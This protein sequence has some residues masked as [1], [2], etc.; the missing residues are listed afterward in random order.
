MT[1]RA[2]WYVLLLAGLTV[3]CSAVL[4]T[5][6][7]GPAYTALELPAF[8]T[9]AIPISAHLASAVAGW[10]ELRSPDLPRRRARR[11]GLLGVAAVFA[12]LGAVCMQLKL[13]H[14]DLLAMLI[15]GVVSGTGPFIVAVLFFPP[16]KRGA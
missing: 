7:I 2:P 3:L 6:T 15:G 8:L 1:P 5:A 4:A 14:F 16:E 11:Q 9:F 13:G 12:A 10:G